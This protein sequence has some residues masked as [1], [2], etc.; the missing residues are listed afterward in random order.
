MAYKKDPMRPSP[1]YLLN[2]L[3]PPDLLCFKH[4]RLL[5]A[6]NFPSSLFSRTLPW[7]SL[8]DAFPP[9]HYVIGSFL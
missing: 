4:N 9:N 2:F 3:F 6:M 8:C 1:T 7:C 5:P